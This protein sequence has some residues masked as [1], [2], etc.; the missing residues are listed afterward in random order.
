MVLG[1]CCFLEA[2]EMPCVES[3]GQVK[4]TGTCWW[5]E[6]SSSRGGRRRLVPSGLGTSPAWEERNLLRPKQEQPHC[7]SAQPLVSSSLSSA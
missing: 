7:D 2:A 4:S 1:S 6:G 3:E 5:W